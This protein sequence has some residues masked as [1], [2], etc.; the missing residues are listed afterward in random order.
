MSFNWRNGSSAGNSLTF[1]MNPFQSIYFSYPKLFLVSY[2]LD[3]LYKVALFF[4]FHFMASG[5]MKKNMLFGLIKV[6][7]DENL[8]M[9][10]QIFPF[11]PLFTV[12]SFLCSDSY[13]ALL[14]KNFIMF[15]IFYITWKKSF[16]IYTFILSRSEFYWFIMILYLYT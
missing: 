2:F 10:P 3:L 15:Y 11:F 9:I 16:I 13:N 7:R 14:K 1:Y 4:L 5:K 8:V 6:I 12:F